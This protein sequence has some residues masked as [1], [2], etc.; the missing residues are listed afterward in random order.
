MKKRTLGRTGFA[1]SDIGFGAWAIGGSWG[2][3]DEGESVKALHAAIDHGLNFIDTAAGYGGGRSERIIGR[4]LKERKEKLYVATKTPPM[5]GAWPPTPYD[6]AEDRYPEKYIRESV[7]ERLKNLGVE[8]ID[9]LQLHTWTRAWNA[10]PTPLHVLAKLKEEGKVLNYGISTPENDQDCVVDLM[11]RGL[12]D[13]VQVIYNIFEQ[14]PAAEL[15]P[16]ARETNTGIIVRV[17]FDEGSLTGKFAADTRFAEGDFRNRYFAGD[18]LE[19]TV[20]RVEAIRELVKESGYTMAQIALLFVLADPAV[21]TVIPGIR[22]VRQAELNTAISDLKPLPQ[23]LID[24]LRKHLWLKSH[25]Y[26]GK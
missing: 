24:E 11:K 9:V 12:I 1:V 16:V 13:T 6:R 3:Q 4:V 2:D 14:Q 10:N 21:S 5:A 15:L 26:S 19:R 7:E 22:N 8:A 25:W 20:A 17:A 18:R 23:T